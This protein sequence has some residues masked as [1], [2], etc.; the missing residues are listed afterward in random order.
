MC[1][2]Y[3][4]HKQPLMDVF[5]LYVQ[6]E[7]ETHSSVSRLAGLRSLLFN[8]CKVMGVHERPLRVSCLAEWTHTPTN[9]KAERPL[10]HQQG[11][12]YVTT[13]LIISLR[14]NRHKFPL[15]L[16]ENPSRN[17]GNVYQVLRN[18]KNC[19]FL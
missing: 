16:S 19:K 8:K 17:N 7:I 15:L 12:I 3:N 14:V 6:T 10:A 13:Q 4:R 18:F 9:C 5:S 2:L 1:L 11:Q